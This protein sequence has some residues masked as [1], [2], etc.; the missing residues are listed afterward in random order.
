MRGRGRGA[1]P[2]GEESPRAAAQSG[3]HRNRRGGRGSS[4]LHGG[5]RRNSDGYH[6][7]LDEAV[8]CAGSFA[9]A[10]T[11]NHVTVETVED[12]HGLASSLDAIWG[13]LKDM[14]PQS[15]RVS[16]LLT[17]QR[18]S[19]TGGAT[20]DVLPP[21]ATARNSPAF[22]LLLRV[23]KMAVFCAQS[24]S[25][26]RQHEALHTLRH[27]L[28]HCVSLQRARRASSRRRGPHH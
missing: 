10:A 21:G 4:Q 22:G 3:P 16:G 13:A 17:L 25:E 20:H 12:D 8:P 23:S 27:P 18:R 28:R 15:D 19:M 11:R 24:S 2:G 26:F 9:Y 5:G 6:R 14:T 7:R 1:T